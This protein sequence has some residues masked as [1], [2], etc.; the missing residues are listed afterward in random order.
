MAASK[1]TAVILWTGIAAAAAGI[2]AVVLMVKRHE[3]DSHA[4]T[5]T[6]RLRDVQDVLSDCYGKISEIEE[7][8]S[9]PLKEAGKS[10]RAGSGTSIS[11]N[12]SP[13]LD[14]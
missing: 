2:A 5:M 10:K 11:S 9:L 14:S 12:G 3:R 13:V 4:E 8:L 6:R 7:R 1:K